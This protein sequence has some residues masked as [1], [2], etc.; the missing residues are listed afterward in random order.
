MFNRESRIQLGGGCPAC[1]NRVNN[2]TNVFHT[3]GREFALE[4]LACLMEHYFIIN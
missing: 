2:S 4:T 3:R 1:N